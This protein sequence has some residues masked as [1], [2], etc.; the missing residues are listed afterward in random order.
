MP[1]GWTRSRHLRRAK[2]Q[3]SV[4]VQWLTF[5]LSALGIV[6]AGIRLAPYG[7]AI[8]KHLRIGQGWIG[9]IF[10]ATLTSIPELTTT[11]TGAAINAPNIALGNAFGSNLFNV[12]IVAIMDILLL[13]RGPFLARVKP[14]HTISGG[15]AILL[16]SLAMVGVVLKPEVSILGVSPIS[17]LLLV[18][19]A[20][21]VYLLFR[22]E[23][24]GTGEEEEETGGEIPSLLRAAVGFAICGVVIIA[25]GIFLMRASKEIAIAT[26]LTDSL[27]GAIFVAI[28]TSLPELTT[29]IGAL[30]IGAVDM[31][32]GN[33]FGSNMFNIL[34]IFFADLAFRRGSI[35]GS[36]GAGEADQLVVASFGILL[37]AIAVVSIAGR[38]RRKVFG[39]G[40]DSALLLVSYGAAVVIIIGRGVQ[41]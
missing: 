23:R 1:G 14:Y 38:P 20:V 8:G 35:Y 15:V 6:V 30:R 2:G 3:D 40:V 39:I 26:H 36:L 31:I 34:T 32:V 27:M 28:I 7:D 4:W 37:T 33:L 21:G 9:L 10:L 18:G 13:G 19:Y 25:A 11:V 16:T 24:E 41:L 22:A 17:L 5:L 12:V 29:S